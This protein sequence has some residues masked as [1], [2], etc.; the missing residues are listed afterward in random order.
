MTDQPHTT[1]HDPYPRDAAEGDP[2]AERR[3]NSRAFYDAVDD[4]IAGKGKAPTY[5]VRAEG[6]AEAGYTI[7]LDDGYGTV[8]KVEPSEGGHGRTLE[9][10]SLGDTVR[11]DLRGSLDRILG[12]ILAGAERVAPITGSR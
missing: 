7:T 10:T 3:R 11:V 2:M 12:G 9:V 6:D 8:V 4:A 5:I 1:S